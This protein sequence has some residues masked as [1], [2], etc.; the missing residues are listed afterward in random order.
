MAANQRSTRAAVAD[1]A[2]VDAVR[3]GD[4][5]AIARAITLV[6]STRDDHRERAEAMLVE[7]LRGKG[8]SIRIGITGVPGVGKSTFIEAL[9]AVAVDQGHRIAVLSIDPSSALSGGSIL[10]D[11]TRMEHLARSPNAY[12]RPS[13]SAG[14]LGGVAR[15]TRESIAVLEAA[16]FDVV[17]VET[18]GVGQSET[19]VAS[20][21]DLF[22]LML[23]PGGGD[24]LQGIKRGIMEL[25]DIAIVNKADGELKSA[26]GRA[27]AEY[28]NAMRLLPRRYREWDVPVLACSARDGDGIDAA[29]TRIGD[30]VTMSRDAGHFQARRAEQQVHW[31]REE[32]NQGLVDV[33]RRDARLREAMQRAE[34]DVLARRATAAGAA[35]RLVETL[36]KSR[37]TSS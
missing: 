2:L 10:G 27:V 33:L 36:I 35:R 31:F 32:L 22:L 7:L 25:A 14:T 15:R 1:G 19:V 34:A 20:M 3:R 5:R 37:S 6:E 9:G 8:E 13:P 26:A 24:E 18:V 29:W 4:R 21:T 11:K 17:V 16:G 28:G 30:F 23:M 12:I